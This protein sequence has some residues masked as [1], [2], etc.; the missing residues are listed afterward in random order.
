MLRL[1]QA[2]GD[3]LV[4]VFRQFPNERAHPGA[5]LVA[6]ASEAAANQGRFWEAHD[7]IYALAAPAAVRAPP[8]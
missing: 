8:R 4:Y 6:R 2:L 3:R 5:E 1:R 7:W